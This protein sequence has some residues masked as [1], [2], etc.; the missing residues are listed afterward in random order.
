[1]LYTWKVR[2]LK[3][4]ALN[5]LWRRWRGARGDRPGSYADIPAY[6]REYA[7]GRSFADIGCM[8]GVN[9]EYAFLAEQSGATSVKAVDLFGPTPEFEETHRQRRSRVEFIL[10]DITQQATL[11]RIGPA[12]VVLCAGVLYHHPSPLALLVALRRICR[13]ALILRSATIPEISGLPHA[14]VFYPRL[15]EGGRRLWNLETLGVAHQSG[16]SKPFDG[17][18]GYDNWFWGITPSCLGALAET[19]GFGIERRAVEAFATTLV[20]EPVG[21]PFEPRPR[22]ADEARELAAAISKA[23]IAKPA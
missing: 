12:D 8:W 23:R 22:G 19:A 14:A 7:R 6:V 11:E 20:C 18:D 13:C 5:R 2:A 4:P 1:M 15:S 9:G 10:G 17:A 16:I 21:A 3:I